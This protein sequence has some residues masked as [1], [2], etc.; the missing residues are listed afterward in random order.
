MSAATEDPLFRD[1][2][3]RWARGVQFGD[4]SRLSSRRTR[5]LVWVLEALVVTAVAAAAIIQVPTTVSGSAVI[6]PDGNRYIAALPAGTPIVAGQKV[7]LSGTGDDLS[8]VVVTGVQRRGDEMLVTGPVTSVAVP[9]GAAIP[10]A[11]RVEA[12]NGTA[13][14]LRLVLGGLLSD[15][16]Q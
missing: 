11:G 7:W 1:Q 8:E 2:A 14:L 3:V 6:Q 9:P 4:P 12:P 5:I 10:R 13:S 16:Q 15:G